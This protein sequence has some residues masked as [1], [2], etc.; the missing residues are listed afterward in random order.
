[1]ELD[2]KFNELSRKQLMKLCS[3]Y[4][5]KI[6]GSMPNQFTSDEDLLN[7]VSDNLNIS[8]DGTILKKGE[9]IDAEIRISK[10]QNRLRM[11]II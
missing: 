11:I 8:E 5:L 9:K 3:Y 7:L 2:L 4:S 10:G 1:M 6:Q